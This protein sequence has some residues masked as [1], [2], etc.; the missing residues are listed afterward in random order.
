MTGR[1]YVLEASMG[2]N[3][4]MRELAGRQHARSAG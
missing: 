2:G 1:V 3:A 4:A